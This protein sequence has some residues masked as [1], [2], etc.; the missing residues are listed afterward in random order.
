MTDQYFLGQC[1]PELRPDF[2]ECV[3]RDVSLP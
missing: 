3:E 2:I 1:P